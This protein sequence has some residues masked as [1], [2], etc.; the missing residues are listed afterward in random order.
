MTSP[1]Q[2]VKAIADQSVS[3]NEQPKKEYSNTP[4]ATPIKSSPELHKIDYAKIFKK[5]RRKIRRF[6]KDGKRKIYARKAYFLPVGIG[7]TIIAVNYYQ[8][9]EMK[10][11]WWLVVMVLFV[12]QH[13]WDEWHR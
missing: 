8:T 2:E 9:G 7:L 1:K 11:L 6:L 4:I 13:I 10:D 3:T 12:Y 5:Y